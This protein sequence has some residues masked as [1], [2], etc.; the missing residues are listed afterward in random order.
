MKDIANNVERQ[1]KVIETRIHL[2]KAL[3]FSVHET[4]A[5]V[6]FSHRMLTVAG[7]VDRNKSCPNNFFGRGS[8]RFVPH[9]FEGE[10]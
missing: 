4:E 5:I 7:N 3:W 9:N 1:L 10:I 6:W 2:G 8:F